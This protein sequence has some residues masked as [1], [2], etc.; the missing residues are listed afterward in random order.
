MGQ[1]MNKDQKFEANA[2]LADVGGTNA[3]FALSYPPAAGRD[4]LVDNIQVY[5]TGDY[6]GFLDALSRYTDEHLN[7]VV[8]PKACFA[9]ACPVSGEIISM[10]NN[11][12]SFSKKSV[13]RHLGIDDI[14]YIN[15]FEANAFS[16]LELTARDLHEIGH[17]SAS[18]EPR[19]S[20]NYLFIG[21]GTGLGVCILCRR[22]AQYFTLSTEGGHSSFAPKNVLQMH[23]LEHL[24][25]R[26]DHISNE[27]VLAGPGI[28]NLYEAMAHIQGQNPTHQTNEEI[29]NAAG[30]KADELSQSTMRVFFNLLAS[31]SSNLAI[32]AGC[33]AGVYVTS[34]IVMK[35]F[36]LLD[37]EEFR[38]HF[39]NRGRFSDYMSKIPIYFVRRPFLGLLGASVVINHPE[40][41]V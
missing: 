23:I 10:T 15:D 37:Q 3:R 11:H 30:R 1:F 39:N 7:G 28:L 20:E 25:K 21:P 17:S 32:S 9:F 4:K 36:A 5:K 29:V 41:T 40:V 6:P 31:V 2:I 26:F 19:T 13:S 24:L 16:I 27:R 22:G 14:A 34:D 12:W 18:G 38:I 35:N 33:T 8:P